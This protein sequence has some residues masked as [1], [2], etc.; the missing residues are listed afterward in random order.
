MPGRRDCPTEALWARGADRA[1]AGHQARDRTGR[2]VGRGS[3]LSPAW[4]RVPAPVP[5]EDRARPGCSETGR[6]RAPD[7]G[8]RCSPSPKARR[9]SCPE[10]PRRSCT[11]ARPPRRQRARGTCGSRTGYVCAAR[12]TGSHALPVEEFGGRLGP[13]EVVQAPARGHRSRIADMSGADRGAYVVRAVAGEQC[14]CAV[15]AAETGPFI[16][17]EGVTLRLPL[18]GEPA[19]ARREP[20]TLGQASQ[21]DGARGVPVVERDQGAPHESV[22]TEVRIAP[23]TRQIGGLAGPLERGATIAKP[24]GPSSV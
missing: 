4:G 8:R 22:G 12:A 3:C 11:R 15:E 7:D 5:V 23:G 2:G 21:G 1:S 10:A 16:A 24:P 13:T 17:D 20:A 9:A 18:S 6:A 19:N 14:S